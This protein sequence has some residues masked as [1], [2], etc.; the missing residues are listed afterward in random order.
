MAVQTADNKSYYCEKCNRTLNATEFYK[1]NNLEK[2]PNEGKFPQCKKCMTMHVNNWEPS[3]YLWILQEAD[4]PYVPDEWNKLMATYA[5]DSSKMTGMTIVGRY[6]GKMQLK[7]Y[8]D[9]RW[10]DT[11]FLQELAQSKIEQ[12]MQRQGYGAQQIAVAVQR[13]AFE[14]PEG[15]LIPPADVPEYDPYLASGEEDYFEDQVVGATTPELDLTPEDI[16]YLRLKWGKS[17]K[18]EEW[19]RLEQLY[20]EM[21]GSYDIQA[22]GHLDTL[23]LVCKTSLKANQLLDIGDVD[24]A[25]K[26]IKMYDG[27]MKSGKFTAAQNKAESG[28]YVDSISELVAICE[29][30]GFIPRFYTDGP[31]DKVDRT[32]QDLQSYTRTLV[33][34]EMNLG[35]LIENA[36][37][38]IELDK[39]KEAEGE[40][41]AADE[42]ELMEISLFSDDAAEYLHDEAF[43]EFRDAEDEWADEDEILLQE[44]LSE[45][46]E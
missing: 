32:L 42:D 25:Q 17:Y 35:N 30:Q 9:Y 16:V 46:E 6:L 21:M 39:Q 12:T 27:L 22:A 1:S 38:Q 45:G 37:K 4:V 44:L 18:P 3:T 31:Q 7:Q 40:S 28:E 14:I 34:E 23:K 26:M 5:K 11:E 2:Y 15:Q 8:R 13:A 33:T 19:V 24:G 10:K 43:G 29:T 20:E 41:E 36:V